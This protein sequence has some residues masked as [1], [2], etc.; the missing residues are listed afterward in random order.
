MDSSTSTGRLI[1]VP[2]LITL[3]VTLARLGAELAG[4]PSWLA[5]RNTGGPGALLGIAWLAPL[6]GIYFATRLAGVE[7]PYR[8]L[9]RT[10]IAYGYAARIPVF[11][12]TMVAIL[13]QWGT[14]YEKFNQD[15]ANQPS[16]W[17]KVGLTAI[18]QLGA[19]VFVWTLGTGMLAGS[20][21]FLYLKRRRPAILPT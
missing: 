8:S 18:F 16:F 21:T 12:I 7:R 17:A 15:P 19:W 6:F 13:A 11:V 10:L 5:N 4:L 14:H 3:V 20:L 2:A 9:A 1:F